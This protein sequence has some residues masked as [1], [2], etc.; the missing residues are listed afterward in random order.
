MAEATN[1]PTKFHC[2]MYKEW[3][4]IFTT[5]TEKQTFSDI[6]SYSH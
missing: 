3:L 1:K 2:Y 5:D 4:R 6:R